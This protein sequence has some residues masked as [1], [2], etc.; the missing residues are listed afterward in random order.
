MSVAWGCFVDPSQIVFHFQ[1]IASQ[2]SWH[3]HITAV[4]CWQLILHIIIKL[5]KLKLTL[6]AV[7]FGLVETLVLGKKHW[8]ELFLR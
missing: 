3:L 2:F 8:S 6:T 7:G 5:F 1:L 4:I